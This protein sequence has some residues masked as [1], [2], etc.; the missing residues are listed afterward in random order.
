M[1]HALSS[2]TYYEPINIELKNVHDVTP[3]IG[4]GLMRGGGCGHA[5]APC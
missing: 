5:A 4:P 1:E 2:S 3:F